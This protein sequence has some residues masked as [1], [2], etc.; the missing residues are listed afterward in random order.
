MI[1][2]FVLVVDYEEALC[3]L[4]RSG[5]CVIE[6]AVTLGYKTSTDQVSAVFGAMECFRGLVVAFHNF[7]WKMVFTLVVLSVLLTDPKIITTS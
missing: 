5:G 2:I 3:F 1:A 4:Q 6:A 7:S